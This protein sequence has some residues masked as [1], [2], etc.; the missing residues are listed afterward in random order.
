MGSKRGGA[1]FSGEYG[2]DERERERNLFN[3]LMAES[4]YGTNSSQ[5]SYL[6]MLP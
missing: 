3:L 5:E 6:T 4:R 2:I 1:Y